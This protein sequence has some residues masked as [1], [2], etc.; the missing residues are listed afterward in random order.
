[1]A[2]L[3]CSSIVLLVTFF[4]LP[5]IYHLPKCVLA[6]V[7]CLV[8]FSL[9]A[10]APNDIGYYWKMEAWIDLTLM[11]LTFTCS[12]VWDVEVGIVVSVILSLLLVVHRSSKTR[13]TILGRI[14]G[15][16][17]WKP[18]SENPEAEED[19]PG[20]LIVRLRENLDFANT[21]QLKERLRRLEL[22][23]HEPRHPSEA[24]RRPQASLLLFHMAD[25]ETCDAT[26]V[27]I[28]YELLA[29]YKNRGVTLLVAHLRDGPRKMFE[30]GGIVALLGEHAF[31]E[32]VA[33]AIA[34]VSHP[35]ES[36]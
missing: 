11:F 6:S 13:M 5:S 7:I 24:P 20:A 34:G 3:V 36:Q 32:S 33:G 23:G 8:V 30:R 35:L 19:I 25:V 29:M 21:A 15:T 4:L 2:S 22:Y 16:D 26:A 12:I 17:R 18:I 9:L 10:E 1:M 27:Q 14:P 28:F 31:Y